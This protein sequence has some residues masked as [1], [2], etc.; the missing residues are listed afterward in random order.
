MKTYRTIPDLRD[1]ISREKQAGKRIGL[2]PTMGFLHEGHLSL[3]DNIKAHCDFIITSIFINPKQ[4]GPGEDLDKYPRNFDRDKSLLQDRGVDAIFF[5]KAD[6]I[7]PED[8]LTFI[9]VDKLGEILCGRS[10]PAHFQGVTTIVTKLF[11]ITKCDVVA[12]G[13]KDYQQAIIIRRMV[14]DL[15]FDLEVLICPTVREEDGL[16]MS[17]RNSYLQP[18]E[19]KRAI[20]LVN[21]FQRARRLYEFGELHTARLR[22]EMVQ[23]IL[24]IPEV[25]IDYI[26]VVDAQT[27]E[28]IDK[29]ERPALLAGAIWLGKARLIDNIII[30][31]K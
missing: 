15:N 5:P 21:A 6:E 27:L 22:D 11:L 26:E 7:Y 29:I 20:C 23:A 25:R 12:F 18:E 28:P 4:F 16:A 24:T 30:E 9:Q 1:C 13:Q 14:E 3:V 2:V 8:Y 31:P 17:S 10:R 19:R